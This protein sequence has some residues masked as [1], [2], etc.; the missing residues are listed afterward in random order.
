MNPPRLTATICLIVLLAALAYALLSDPVP[1]DPGVP[2]TSASPIPLLAA[3]VPPIG[4]FRGE[5]NVNPLNPFVPF[6]V[7]NEEVR[8]ITAPVR[9]GPVNP[10]P[11]PAPIST[12]VIEE[13]KKPQY[14]TLK[15]RDAG[16]PECLGVVR[17]GDTAVLVARLPGQEKVGIETGGEL[18]GW[19]LVGIEFGVA[20]FT[21]PAGEMHELPIGSI[22]A[23]QVL[24]HEE[25]PSEPA[26]APVPH[27]VTVPAQAPVPLRPGPAPAQTPAPQASQPP[28]QPQ[29]APE[30]RTLRP[31][32]K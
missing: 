22:A 8:S 1:L 19:K 26:P 17:K 15:P 6:D 11:V 4:D 7:R 31:R 2:H 3:S 28:M 27:A 20:R 25:P 16:A 32:P 18:G 14:P 24:G 29:P 23:P 30:L 21:D 10:I 5:F 9:V 12:V 13:P